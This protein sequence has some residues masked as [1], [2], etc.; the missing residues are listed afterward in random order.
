MQLLEAVAA[1]ALQTL[2]LA[3]LVA[4]LTAN[5]VM[6][7]RAWQIQDRLA[8]TRQIEHFVDRTLSRFDPAAVSSPI[9]TATRPRLVVSGC[10]SKAC[11]EHG[12]SSMPTTFE[13]RADGDHTK[14]LLHRIGRQTMTIGAG[15]PA[16]ARFEY[17]NHA[18]GSVTST[19]AISILSI[20]AGLDRIVA[21]TP[22]GHEPTR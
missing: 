8:T 9:V 7:H 16:S 17:W 4:A 6:V 2:V 10:V 22:P 13:L 21:A 20:P 12:T 14:R 11:R 1:L 18:G 5:A 19:P 3:N 15:I